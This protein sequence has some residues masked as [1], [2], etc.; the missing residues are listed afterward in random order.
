M[1]EPQSIDPKNRAFAERHGEPSQ[2]GLDGGVLK[3]DE[4]WSGWSLAKLSWGGRPAI[5]IR[6]NGHPG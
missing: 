6:W 1:S 2:R 3:D 4:V 5:G